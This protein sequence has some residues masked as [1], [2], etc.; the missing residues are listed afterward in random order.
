MSVRKALFRLLLTVFSLALSLVAGEALLRIVFRDHG[1]ATMNGPGGGPFEYTY[2]DSAKQ[3]RGPEAL[4]PRTAGLARIL[5][6]GDSISW[7]W[8]VRDWGAIWPNQML[9]ALN[10]TGP[11]Y[12]MHLL[13]SA[14]TEV[15]GH[16]LHLRNWVGQVQPDIIVYQWYANDLEVRKHRP[17]GQR[18]WQKS[19]WWQ[20]VTT[21]SYLA[22]F[23]DN[24]LSGL[25]PPPGR[26]Y[27][28]YLLEDFAP[29][30][31]GWLEFETSF[32]ALAMLANRSASRTILLLYP[33]LPY[34]GK[35]QLTVIS[36]RMKGLA[37]PHDLVI[38]ASLTPHDVGADAVEPGPPWMARRVMG[39]AGAG[40]LVRTPGLELSPGAQSIVVRMRAKGVTPDAVQHVEIVDR[41]AKR[42]VATHDVPGAALSTTGWSDVQVPFTVT[43]TAHEFEVVVRT[44]AGAALAIDSVRF[45]VRY[46][47][48][49]VDPTSE[50]ESFPTWVSIFD[51]H[52]NARAHAVLAHELA[53]QIQQGAPGGR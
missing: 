14:G 33:S 27:A 44:G 4:G 30:T 9:A 11:R 37:A 17:E 13:A 21:H 8:G 5:V 32:H 22:Y 25:L 1:T 49:I 34:R 47:L 40:I 19:A 48:E 46:R 2:F 51:G 53:M 16:L 35:S 18:D 28:N 24:R 45:P 31:R 50:L 52:P 38:P 42:V 15:D 3:L 23:L 20:A 26:T 7:G 12:D 6:L 10:A 41:T 39:E 36:D 43:D 29:G